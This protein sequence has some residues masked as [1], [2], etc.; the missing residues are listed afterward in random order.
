MPNK[1]LIVE[2]EMTHQEVFK[3]FVMLAY[4]YLDKEVEIVI[5]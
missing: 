4:L 3:E 1:I 2:D 5:A